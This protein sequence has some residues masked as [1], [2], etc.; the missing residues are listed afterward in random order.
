[1][2]ELRDFFHLLFLRKGPQAT[3]KGHWQVPFLRKLPSEIKI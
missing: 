2:Q 3:G 1:M